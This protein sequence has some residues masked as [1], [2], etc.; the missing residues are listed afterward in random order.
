MNQHFFTDLL[1]DVL[2]ASI[3]H[4]DEYSRVSLVSSS[5]HFK[6]FQRNAIPISVFYVSPRLAYR[7]AVRL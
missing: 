1:A 3:C 2:T 7:S 6:I 4:G 5:H